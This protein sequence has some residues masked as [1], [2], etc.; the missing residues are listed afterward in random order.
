MAAIAINPSCSRYRRVAQVRRAAL[1]VPLPSRS[2][3]RLDVADQPAHRRGTRRREQVATAISL[4]DG[5]ATVPMLRAPIFEDKVIDF[6]VELAKIVERRSLVA[7]P[8]SAG[9]DASPS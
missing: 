7:I 8:D 2:L 1:A 6:I 4:L 5:G 3:L 9:E